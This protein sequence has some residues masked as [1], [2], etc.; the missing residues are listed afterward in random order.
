MQQQIKLG[1]VSFMAISL[2]SGC[3]TVDSQSVYTSAAPRATDSLATPPGLTAPDLTTNYKMAPLSSNGYQVANTSGM[4]IETGGSQRWLVVESQ[5]VTALWPM[6]LGYFNQ[7][8]LTVK[9]QNPALGVLQ[10]DW[11]ARD[12]KVPQGDSIRGAFAW[13]G[14]DSMYSLNSM[15]MYRVSLWQDGNRVILMDTNYQMDEEY[16]G[17]HSPG[18]A[19]TS[20]LAAS[21]SQRTKWMSRPSNPQLELEF[22]TQFMAFAGMPAEQIKKIALVATPKVAPLVNNQIIVNDPF[23][24]AWWRT[25]L[26]LDRV[27]LGVVDKNRSSGEY[28]VYPLQAQIDNPEPGFFSKWFAAKNESGL[29]TGPK[30]VYTLKLVAAATTTIIS[31]NLYASSPQDKV[32]DKNLVANQQKYLAALAAQLQ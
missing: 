2:I 30:P 13:I 4:H 23:D 16:E 25:A 6:V 15:Y 14:W 12:T 10:S 32:P 20:S 9:Y 21:D 26:A 1:I 29:S 18:I 22:L 17:C 19:N 28:Y 5:S 8:G 31:L 11:A 24:R 27:G 7:I 3:G